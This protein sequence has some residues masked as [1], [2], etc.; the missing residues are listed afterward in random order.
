[1]IRCILAIFLLFGLGCEDDPPPG[2]GTID[3]AGQR[4]ILD[5][6]DYIS[7]SRTMNVPLD[8]ASKIPGKTRS[9]DGTDSILYLY[10][11]EPTNKLIAVNGQGRIAWQRESGTDPKESFQS[12]SKPFLEDSTLYVYDRAV[13]KR[14]AYTAAGR[15]VNSV[16]VPYYF[17]DV[18]HLDD[19][20]IFSVGDASN[21]SLDDAALTTAEV[22]SVSKDSLSGPVTVLRTRHTPRIAGKIIYQDNFDLISS[23]SELYYHRNFDDSLARWDGKEFTHFTTL[24]FSTQ[25]RSEEIARDP[26]VRSTLSALYDENIPN[27]RFAAPAGDLM[28]VGYTYDL[29]EYTGVLRGGTF[30]GG[31]NLFRVGDT[32]LY[33]RLDFSNGRLLNQMYRTAYDYLQDFMATNPRADYANLKRAMESLPGDDNDG[34]VYTILDVQ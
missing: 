13:Q 7:G 4:D 16:R 20:A 21:E 23:G 32:Y 27:I 24:H 34:I 31:S 6:S 30:V 10:F 9:F 15:F 22:F 18:F 11:Q 12:V 14:F 33:G 19:R 26:N 28:Y 17:N 25:D 29:T 2:G 5:L 1:M 8:E 3:L